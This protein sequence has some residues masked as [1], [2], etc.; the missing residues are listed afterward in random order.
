MLHSCPSCRIVYEDILDYLPH[1]LKCPMCCALDYA[2]KQATQLYPDLG[3]EA[4]R[5]VQFLRNA[6][7]RDKLD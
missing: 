4:L 6:N 1:T 5:H 7:S 2:Q 3:R